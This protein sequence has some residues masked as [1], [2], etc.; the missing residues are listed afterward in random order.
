MCYICMYVCT[1]ASTDGQAELR[2]VDLRGEKIPTSQEIYIQKVL[3]SY[4]FQVF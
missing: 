2:N 1:Y 4:I 3:V